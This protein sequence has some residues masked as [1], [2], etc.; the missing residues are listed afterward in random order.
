[1]EYDA[2]DLIAEYRC[3]VYITD[4]ACHIPNSLGITK[5]GGL[6]EKSWP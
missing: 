5:R 1:M 2:P 6:P 4:P 3:C